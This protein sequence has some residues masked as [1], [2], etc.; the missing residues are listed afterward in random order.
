[1]TLDTR[2]DLTLLFVANDAPSNAWL[3][4]HVEHSHSI[5]SILRPDW[6]TAPPAERRA[7]KRPSRPFTTRVLRRLRTHYFASHDVHDAARLERM[8]FPAAAPSP[9]RAPVWTVPAWDI[10]SS[11]VQQRIEAIS[12]DLIILSGAPLLR[13]NIFRI[14][15]LGTLN[16][17]FGISPTYRGMH[18]ILTPWQR[19]DF[20]HV[21]ATLHR[22]TDG[23]DNGP[24]LFR[25]YPALAPDDDHVSAEAKIVR[26]A[27]ETLSHTL[28]WLSAHAGADTAMPGRAL[29]E[30]GELIRFHDRSVRAHLRARVS[31]VRPPA[32]VERVEM[33][34]RE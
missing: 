25:V 29:D 11:D 28:S 32:T 4:R 23:I 1:V 19:G 16:L 8:L 3:I 9:A 14:P 26:L 13:P 31:A 27:S 33:L 18:T 2:P 17:H 12:P 5:H 21:G 34:Y 6:Q 15:R 20:A 7:H 30:K 24:V 22:V 10:N